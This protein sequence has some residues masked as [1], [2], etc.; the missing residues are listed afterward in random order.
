MNW[1]LTRPNH[2]VSF[3]RDEPFC[4]LVPQRR[5]ELESFHTEIRAIETDP[6]T[7]DEFSAFAERRHRMQVNKF[8]SKYTDELARYRRDWERDYF[9]GKSASG[10]RS[11]EHQ[12][13]LHLRPFRSPN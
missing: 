3:E 9:H 10:A 12:T 2:S 8:L 6:Q 7:S 13:R 1:K 5:G 4:M 11:P